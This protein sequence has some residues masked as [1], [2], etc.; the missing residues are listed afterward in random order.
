[1]VRHDRLIAKQ[2]RES[3]CNE[4]QNADVTLEISGDIDIESH[5]LPFFLLLGEGTTLFCN[6]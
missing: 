5:L 2:A 4:R 1:M 6:K 3:L